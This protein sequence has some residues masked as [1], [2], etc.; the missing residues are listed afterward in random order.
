MHSTSVTQRWELRR[1]AARFYKISSPTRGGPAVQEA[2][3]EI[4][5][6]AREGRAHARTPIEL[7]APPTR[8]PASLLLLAEAGM[9]QEGGMSRR[10]G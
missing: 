2:D 3:V 1:V 8:R 10:Y 6:S 7:G 4:L 5:G 9:L